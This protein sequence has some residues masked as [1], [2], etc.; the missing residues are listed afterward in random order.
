MKDAKKESDNAVAW[1]LNQKAENAYME[2]Y[3]TIYTLRYLF[4]LAVF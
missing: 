3:S 4:S 2:L 1:L